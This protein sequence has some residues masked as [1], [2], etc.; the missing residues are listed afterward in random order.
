M[1]YTDLKAAI[2]ANADC[3]QYV[4]TNDVEGSFRGI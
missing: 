3:T 2:L 4:I 1:N